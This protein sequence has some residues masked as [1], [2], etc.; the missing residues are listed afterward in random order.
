MARAISGYFRMIIMTPLLKKFVL[1]IIFQIKSPLAYAFL[2]VS[3][4]QAS[5]DYPFSGQERLTC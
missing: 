3:N 2:T 5:Q 4:I 1:K